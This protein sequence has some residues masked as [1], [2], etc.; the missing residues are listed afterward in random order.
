[1][2]L[3]ELEPEGPTVTMSTTADETQWVGFRTDAARVIA[4]TSRYEAAV[5]ES[6]ESTYDE[7]VLD[8]LGDAVEGL[9]SAR[10]S[11]LRLAQLNPAGGVS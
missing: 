1:M 7:Q 6:F 11:A 2:G 5:A 8:R 3:E 9:R 4:A 10:P